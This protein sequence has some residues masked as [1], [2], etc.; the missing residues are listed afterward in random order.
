MRF[1]LKGLFVVFLSSI[2]LTK[3]QSKGDYQEPERV[4][5]SIQEE[6]SLKKNVEVSIT[7]DE[8]HTLHQHNRLC[9]LLDTIEKKTVKID[10]IN[11]LIRREF[12]S[13]DVGYSDMRVSPPDFIEGQVKDAK[14]SIHNLQRQR[15]LITDWKYLNNTFIEYVYVCSAI[16]REM[17]NIRHIKFT[18]LYD[19]KVKGIFLHYTK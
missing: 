4:F 9:F 19:F 8:L 14:N 13:E 1:L 3:V 11:N 10:D 17:E 12:G 5:F 18:P 7:L 16:N 2:P 6:M 15:L